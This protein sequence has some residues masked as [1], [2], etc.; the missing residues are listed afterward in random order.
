[1]VRLAI[2][3]ATCLVVG[4]NASGSPPASD[5]MISVGQHHLQVHLAGTGTPTVV[6]DAGLGEGCEKWRPLQERISRV[7]RV[8]TYNRA[9]YGESERGPLPRDCV[10][11]AT[12]LKALLDGSSVPGPYL[13]VGHSLGALNVQVFASKYPRDTV[14]IVLLDPPPLSF[15]RREEYTSL[16]AMADRMTADWQAAA[17]S[18]TK[19]TDTQER[20]RAVFLEMIASEHR[21]MFGDSARLVSGISSFGQ[22]PLLVMSAGKPNPSF[23]GI[24]AE[25]QRYWIEQSRALSHK[26]SKGRF[27]LAEESTHHLHVD[28]PR[29]VEESIVSLVLQAR[30][31]Q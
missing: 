13:V 25:Y 6:I 28:V 23:G 7:T 15:I 29:L 30:G 17:D 16:L 1:M 5:Q 2:L 12:E 27:I 22:I 31:E 19:S 20:S 24:A 11:E 21:E 9:G 4:S 14:G 18:G 26:S 3:F 8:I 10:R